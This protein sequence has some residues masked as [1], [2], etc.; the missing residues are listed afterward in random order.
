MDTSKPQAAPSELSHRNPI[1]IVDALQSML[2]D[3]DGFMVNWFQR[4]NHQ[5]ELDASDSTPDQKLRVRIE[6]FRREKN[7]WKLKRDREEEHIKAK[8]QQLTD[9]WLNLETEQRKL[10]Q[11]KN[12]RPSATFESPSPSVPPPTVVTETSIAQPAEVVTKVESS[13]S[14]LPFPS[15]VSQESVPTENAVR[16]FQRLRQEIQSRRRV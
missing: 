4:L 10:L 3:V 1:E 16:Q 8:F 14:N 15:Q 11:L 2:T 12:A 5:L 13:E 6:E 7:E 9:A